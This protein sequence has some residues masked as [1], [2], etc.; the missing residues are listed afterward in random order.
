M[1]GPDFALLYISSLAQHPPYALDQTW[2]TMYLDRPRRDED[3]SHVHVPTCRVT[4]NSAQQIRRES[5]PS[6]LTA[7]H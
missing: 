7:I 2:A 1:V 6:T 4:A 5:P 3:A